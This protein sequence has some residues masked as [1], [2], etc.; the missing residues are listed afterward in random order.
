[1]PRNVPGNV[2]GNV[3]SK[4]KPLNYI[5]CLPEYK[6]ALSIFE[7]YYKNPKIPQ[8]CPSN[9]RGMCPEKGMFI[10]TC[11]KLERND[12]PH[13]DNHYN[14]INWNRSSRTSYFNLKGMCVSINKFNLRK[15]PNEANFIG[16]LWLYHV[17]DI[18][19][20]IV[21]TSF[22]WCVVYSVKILQA[23]RKIEEHN[24]AEQIDKWINKYT[25][26]SEMQNIINWAN[27]NVSTVVEP[28]DDLSKMLIK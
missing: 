24:A 17:Y 13:I 21:T 19:T 22:L 20:Q 1:M 3:P 7:K 16:K 12:F 10:K 2:P 26:E 8:I 4:G 15:S 18:N 23:Y 5:A 28:W 6:S 9:L 14:Y 25:Q 11:R 27:E